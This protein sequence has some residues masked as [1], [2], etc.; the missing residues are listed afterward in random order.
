VV[1]RFLDWRGFDRLDELD[2]RAGLRRET[3]EALSV[4]R[5]RRSLWVLAALVLVGAAISVAQHRW[6]FVVFDGVVVTIGA[7][8]SRRV[9]RKMRERET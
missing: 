1:V 9:I 4:E 5:I 3:P 7:F 6:A 8:W 2:R